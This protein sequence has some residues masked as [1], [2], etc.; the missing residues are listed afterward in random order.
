MHGLCW[1]ARAFGLTVR[2]DFVAPGLDARR[3]CAGERAVDVSL[4]SHDYIMARAGS[5]LERRCEQV[6]ASGQLVMHIDRT[7]ERS[8]VIAAPGYGT[9]LVAADGREV[10]VAPARTAAWRWQ[11]YLV[12]QALPLAALLQGLEILHA[13]ALVV[14]GRALAIAGA[15]GSGKTTLATALHQAGAGLLCDDVLALEPA[16]ASVLAHPG[17]PLVNLRAGGASVLRR[18]LRGCREVGCDGES[19]R[20]EMDA[21]AEAAPLTALYILDRSDRHAKLSLERRRR[22]AGALLLASSFNFIITDAE[23]LERQLDV[24]ARVAGAAVV[25]SARVPAKMDPNALARAVAADMWEV[26]ACAA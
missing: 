12:G 11:R 7:P 10:L 19:T 25:V 6:G 14:D 2:G 21:T 3:D 5:E 22:G 26:S 20:L 16:G 17:P 13:S 8:H 9:F 24:C 1:S 23:R 15:P 18:P 4:E